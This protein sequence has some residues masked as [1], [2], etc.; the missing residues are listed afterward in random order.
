MLNSATKTLSGQ[1]QESVD[2]A[3]N[4]LETAAIST[5]EF[6]DEASEALKTA[7]TQLSTLAESLRVYAVDATRDA[8][9]FTK[10]EVEAHPLASLAAAITAVVAVMGLVAVNRR[11]KH[12]AT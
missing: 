8:A 7:T 10:H 2:T 12:A 3:A 1:F 6:S 9:Q 5:H 4:A 11:G